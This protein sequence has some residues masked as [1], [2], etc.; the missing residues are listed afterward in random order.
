ML[1]DLEQRTS[2][3]V[4]SAKDHLFFLDAM[5]IIHQYVYLVFFFISWGTDFF[6][7]FIRFHCDLSFSSWTKKVAILIMRRTIFSI[8]IDA[9]RHMLWWTIA[10]ISIF[11]QSWELGYCW[12]VNKAIRKLFEPREDACFDS[13]RNVSAMSK[14]CKIRLKLNCH[15]KSLQILQ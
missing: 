8:L 6:L 2:L 7:Y 12:A 9:I 14:I 4:L 1:S 11:L 15:G 5:G 3:D 13:R 10:H